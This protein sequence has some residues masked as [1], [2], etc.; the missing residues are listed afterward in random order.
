MKSTLYLLGWLCLCL[1]VG[2]G[3]GRA[4]APGEWYVALAKPAWT[5]PGWVFAPVWTFLY[6]LMAVA[7]WLVSRSG[8][9]RRRRLPLTLFGLQLVCNGLWSWLFFGLQRP[10]LALL[11]LV[12]LWL[13]LLPTTT[14]FRK[15][16]P[17]AGY[18][19]WPYLAW[20]TFAAA[21]NFEIWR[22]N[23]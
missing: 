10:G 17:L 22:L 8:E 11:D 9:F 16:R 14:L 19:M 3:T 2:L 20:V 6:I 12:L 23:G 7:A 13:V 15:T 1:G 4:F 18:L 21:L 5:P